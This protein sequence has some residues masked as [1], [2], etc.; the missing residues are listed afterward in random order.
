MGKKL[1]RDSA[2]FSVSSSLVRAAPRRCEGSSGTAAPAAPAAVPEG[3]RLCYSPRVATKR[4]S[5]LQIPQGTEGFYLEEAFRHRR[6]VSHLDS[7]FESWGY[8][9]VYTPVFDFFDIYRSLLGDEAIETVYRLIDRDGDLLLL[10]SDITLFLAK[11]MGVALKERDLPVRVYYS[12]VI[13][14]HQNREDISRNEFFQSGIELIG[15]S[16]TDAD[17]EVLVLLERTLELLGLPAFIHLG[18]QSLFNA[19]FQSIPDAARKQLV[20]AIALRDAREALRIL[21]GWDASLAELCVRIMMFI[22][23]GGGFSS[24]DHEASKHP[25]FPEAARRELRY[26]KALLDTL[27]RAGA[28]Q[29]IRLDLSEIGAQP[30]YTGIVFRAFLEG[31]D[32]AIASGG[33]YDQ[34]MAHFGFPA[35]S[36]GFSLLLRKVEPFVSRPER[37]AMPEVETT[38]GASFVERLAKA[39]R[40]RKA[41]RMARL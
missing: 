14:R 36:V 28:G 24:L 11:Q 23:D 16:G 32:S 25:S 35:P 29:S 40:A 3:P 1:S 31:Q 9:P 33:R 6:I 15:K 39:D 17:L 10:R 41:G 8:L 12:D 38:G 37:F 30:Y 2:D 13:L 4:R 27:E 20:G 21:A 5:F 7:L 26:L 19:C 34:L 18:S 22:G